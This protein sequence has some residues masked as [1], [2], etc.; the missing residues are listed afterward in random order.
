MEYI[1]R[2]KGIKNSLVELQKEEFLGGLE[3]IVPENRFK[4]LVLDEKSLKM[5][6]KVAALFEVLDLDVKRIELLSRSRKTS[7]KTE[8][9]YMVSPTVE[10]V[11][12][13]VLDFTKTGHH[14]IRGNMYKCAHLMFTGE[15]PKE[16]KNKLRKSSIEKF[17]K[18][19]KV[20][21]VNF[22]PIESNVFLTPVITN[23]QEKYLGLETTN[24][25]ITEIGK[26]IIKVC[27]VLGEKPKIRYLDDNSFGS[28]GYT[29]KLAEYIETNMIP[30]KDNINQSNNKTTLL[31]L[32][33]R[34]DL[35][36]PFLH[37]LTYEAMVMDIATNCPNIDAKERKVK[38]LTK[39]NS[40]LVEKTMYLS[41]SNKFWVDYR[42]SYILDAIDGISK[43]SEKFEAENMDVAML[44]KGSKTHPPKIKNVYT[45]N[46]N[47]PQESEKSLNRSMRLDIANLQ[48]IVGKIPRFNEDLSLYNAHASLLEK[49][50]DE[51]NAQQLLRISFI[52]QNIVTGTTP[53]NK[54]YKTGY[55]DVL[56]ILS[57][58]N[59]DMCN[60]ERLTMIYMLSNFKMS[61]EKR[62]RIL[63][64]TGFSSESL[65]KFRDTYLLG[66]SPILVSKIVNSCIKRSKLEKRNFFDASLMF[67]FNISFSSKDNSNEL[68]RHKTILSYIAHSATTGLLDPQL[69]P[70]NALQIEAATP[71]S[72]KS[73]IRSPNSIKSP[74]WLKSPTWQKSTYDNGD[75]SDIQLDYDKRKLFYKS[76]EKPKLI[77]FIVGGMT[78]SEVRDAAL[79]GKEHKTEIYIGST[80]FINPND[81]LHSLDLFQ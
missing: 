44:Q 9:I 12:Q 47:Y 75:G 40:R 6:D 34:M 60:K 15:I 18:S 23:Q 48:K 33:R 11:D 28:L 78:Y 17:I 80:N 5:I 3:S 10:N 64:Y 50:I 79:I 55:S 25:N 36:T 66:N 54:A 68:D 65:E 42:Y 46:S 35:Y 20:L 73:P 62:D 63:A 81:L 39:Q 29:K 58:E 2:A 72:T 49:C 70:P 74:L 71:T 51:F 41:E 14:G 61:K 4:I 30:I 13:I 7:K 57:D 67:P 52:E 38:Y 24:K 27:Q 16:V 31:I 43:R 59:I 45:F 19:L 77:L 37:E 8:A 56:E 26:Q 22:E 32:D 69:F 1:N 76:S 21:N 53:D